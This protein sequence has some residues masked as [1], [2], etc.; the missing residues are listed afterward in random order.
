MTFP[1]TQ[2]A[3]SRSRTAGH[4]PYRQTSRKSRLPHDGVAAVV[5]D[6]IVGHQEIAEEPQQLFLFLLQRLCNLL[7]LVLELGELCLLNLREQQ[8]L[9]QVHRV[10]ADAT[11]VNG[12][13]D[14]Q[15]AAHVRRDL[16]EHDVVG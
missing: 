7:P 3:C 16:D 9:Q 11:L 1:R 4:C 13:K 2:T 15:R 10:E 5:L 8:V 6:D 12:L 14:L